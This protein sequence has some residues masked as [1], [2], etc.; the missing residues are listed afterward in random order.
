MAPETMEKNEDGSR[1]RSAHATGVGTRTCRTHRV[2]QPEVKAASPRRFTIL[3]RPV[4]VLCARWVLD[5]L[6]HP[7]SHV[8][9]LDMAGVES[10]V[11]A[12]I[13]DGFNVDMA[14]RM[15]WKGNTI[16]GTGVRQR[17]GIVSACEEHSGYEEKGTE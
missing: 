8:G 1:S 4:D 7:R 3:A 10:E 14:T 16:R 5:P 13:N 17:V 11:T 9:G 6:G 15:S 2:K 12:L